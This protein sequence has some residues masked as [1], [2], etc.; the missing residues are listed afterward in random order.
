MS[1]QTWGYDKKEPH[2]LRSRVLFKYFTV[3]KRSKNLAIKN[4]PNIIIKNPPNITIKNPRN[5]K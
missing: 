1:K 4:L 2:P 5:I 3:N